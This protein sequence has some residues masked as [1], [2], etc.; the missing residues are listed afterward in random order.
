MLNVNVNVTVKNCMF[1]PSG[2][3]F[4]RITKALRIAVRHGSF[5]CCTPV[6]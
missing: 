6:T 2:F 5:C 4:R 3:N 1:E